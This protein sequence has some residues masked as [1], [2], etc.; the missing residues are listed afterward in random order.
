MSLFDDDKP[1]PK[2]AHELGSDLSALSVDE[3]ERRVGVLT[4][5]IDRLKAEIAAKSSSRNAAEN[6]FKR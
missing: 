2:P 4:A 6:F 1:R 5:E 3:L